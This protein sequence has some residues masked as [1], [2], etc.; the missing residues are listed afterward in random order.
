[1]M[2]D[3]RLNVSSVV[4]LAPWL[5]PENSAE[6]IQAAAGKAREEIE[7]LLARRFP[8]T[9]SL[10]IVCPLPPPGTTPQSPGT[11]IAD[12]TEQFQS[13]ANRLPHEHRPRTIPIADQRFRVEITLAQ[14]EHEDL[15]M[16]RNL[17][18]HKVPSGAPS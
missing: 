17:L 7:L 2:A 15:Q 12:D 9:E 1:M 6:L 4:V 11:V 8:R 13:A 5:R 18:S 14:S 10:S 16:L 3:G